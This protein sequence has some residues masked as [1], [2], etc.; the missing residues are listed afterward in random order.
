M[1]VVNFM[2]NFLKTEAFALNYFADY[3]RDKII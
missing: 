1:G 2:S 3:F